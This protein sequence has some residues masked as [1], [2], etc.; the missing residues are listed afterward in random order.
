[1]C[2]TKNLIGKKFYEKWEIDR[3]SFVPPQFFQKQFFS[4]GAYMM[5]MSVQF[6]LT[7]RR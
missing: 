7:S 5:N 6:Q 3:N 2:E 1:M 4:F